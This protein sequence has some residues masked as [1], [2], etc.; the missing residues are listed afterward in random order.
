MEQDAH[1]DYLDVATVGV[2]RER[3]RHR[4]ELGRE[5]EGRQLGGQACG[6]DSTMTD[7]RGTS[8]GWTG[9]WRGQ[10]H[11]RREREGRQLGGQACGGDSAMTDGRGTSAGRTGLWRGQ[12]HDG[13]ERDVRPVERTAP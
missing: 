13:R 10:R 4:A 11:D 2:R 3:A 12:R 1:V 9:L 6:R 8:A 7:G 5:V